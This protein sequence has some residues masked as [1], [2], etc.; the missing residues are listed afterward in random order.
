MEEDSFGKGVKLGEYGSLISPPEWSGLEKALIVGSE[1]SGVLGLIGISA[2]TMGFLQ[3]Q[4]GAFVY[5]G[6][7]SLATFVLSPLVKKYGCDLYMQ[8]S[9]EELTQKHEVMTEQWKKEV[10][11]RQER[12]E[13]GSGTTGF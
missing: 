6:L 7:A 1:I 12:G 2:S 5:S 13:G 10:N 9:Y 11:E 4:K 3:T 8:R